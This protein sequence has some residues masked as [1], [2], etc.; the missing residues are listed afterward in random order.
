M[1]SILESGVAVGLSC[2]W[3]GELY[4]L[5]TTYN[6]LAKAGYSLD[7]ST[8]NRALIN[9]LSNNTF[10]MERESKDDA[11]LRQMHPGNLVPAKREGIK[12]ARH[13]LLTTWDSVLEVLSL[14]LETSVTGKVLTINFRYLG[15]QENGK[16]T[17]SIYSIST[18]NNFYLFRW[19]KWYLSYVRW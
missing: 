6:I 8:T 5:V 7:S 3:L 14:P 10:P 2:V 9:L 17:H 18:S 19:S 16:R 13:V 15:W 12:F 4:R 1:D 11:F